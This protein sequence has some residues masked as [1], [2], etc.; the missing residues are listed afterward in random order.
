VLCGL[1]LCKLDQ[2]IE[3][4]KRR[5]DDLSLCRHIGLIEAAEEP[6]TGIEVGGHG[7]GRLQRHDCVHPRQQA[8]LEVLDHG[9]P[10]EILASG[11]FEGS[12]NL[13]QAFNELVALEAH[14]QSYSSAEHELPLP[15]VLRKS[16]A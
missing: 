6:P 13:P 12:P 16:L 15:G 4:S 9:D 8:F 2:V 1:P 14:S 3:A 11:E 10:A 5:N 7:R